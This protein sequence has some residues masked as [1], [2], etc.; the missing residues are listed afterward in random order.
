MRRETLARVLFACAHC[1]F[2]VPNHLASAVDKWTGNC[3]YQTEHH[4][5]KNLVEMFVCLFCQSILRLEIFK[6]LNAAGN[7][8]KSGCADGVVGVLC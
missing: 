6:I 8:D 4:S 5:E 7:S 2:W 1:W 3:R